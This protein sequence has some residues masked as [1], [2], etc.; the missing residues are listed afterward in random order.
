MADPSKLTEEER[1]EIME[2]FS[3]T[4]NHSDE[5]F[6]PEMFIEKSYSKNDIKYVLTLIL[7]NKYIILYPLD[8][9]KQSKSFP[10]IAGIPIR[11]HANQF[12]AEN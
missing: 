11:S 3:Q 9:S 8:V 6:G 10:I 1:T 5:L 12:Q 2:Q 7:R 4:F